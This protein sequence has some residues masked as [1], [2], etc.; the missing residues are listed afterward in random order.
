MKTLKKLVAYSLILCL[1]FALASCGGSNSAGS[2]AVTEDNRSARDKVYE[3]IE[4]DLTAF[5]GIPGKQLQDR[6]SV[7]KGLPVTKKD[8][9]TIGYA[10]GSLGSPFFVTMHR[11]LEEA[12]AEAGYT[13][14]TQV[15]NFNTEQSLADMR[16]FIV[17]G[18]DII[19][20]NT[21]VQAA[22]AVF[23]EASEAGIPVIATS[24]Q[25]VNYDSNVIT[26]ILSGSYKSGFYVGEYVAKQMHKKGESIKVGFAVIQIGS[27]DTESRG[28]GFVGGYLYAA[29]QIDGNP[30][31]SKWEAIYDG[32]T[33]WREFADKRSKSAPDMGLELL[34]YGQTANANPDAPGGR[35]ATEDLIAV[36]PNLDLLVV[37]CD[38][39]WPGAAQVLSENN[40]T[41]G[42]DIQIACCADG[43]RV[44]ME[45][46]MRGEILAIGNNSSRMNSIGM[47]TIAKNIF[48]DGK[49]MNNIVANTYTP[50]I[51]ITKEN[52]NEFYNPDD[53]LAMGLQY[54]LQTVDSYNSSVS[55]T[56][57]P[58]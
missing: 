11:A 20:A 2:G 48:I 33:I 10:T 50:T 9:L 34:S 39:M 14:I 52:V 58:F 41:P 40:R 30:Y 12:C 55:P 19:F 43:T 47:M 29:R 46:L 42:G 18:V 36:L 45:A 51:A 8:R 31:P 22:S 7:V 13:L 57:D 16:A 6:S 3:L 1:L 25:P 54:E 26:D 21:D 23:R 5:N 27:G 37:E 38:P 32:Y 28:N 15:S 53:D 17:Q 4:K 35:E 56:A 24:N 44:G 49:D